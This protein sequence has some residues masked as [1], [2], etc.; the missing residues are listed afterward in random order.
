MSGSAVPTCKAY[1]FGTVLPTLF[2]PPAQVTYGLPGSFEG[3]DM[4]T[5]GNARVTCETPVM[6]SARRVEEGIEL[7]VMISCYRAGGPEAQ[8]QATEAAYAMYSTFRDHFRATGNETLGGACREARVT[9]HELIEDDDPDD[10][11]NGRLSQIEI[12][13]SIK[14]RQ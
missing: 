14:A 7:S 4:V 8:Q 11:T 1:L 10:I 12:T 2:P 13:L 6:G 3:N 9:S 5:V